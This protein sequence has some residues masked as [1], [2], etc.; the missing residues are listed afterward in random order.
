MGLAT[1]SVKHLVIEI[2][3]SGGQNAMRVIRPGPGQAEEGE[4]VRDWAL[5]STHVFKHDPSSLG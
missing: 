5:V 4:F 2:E 1:G 3:I